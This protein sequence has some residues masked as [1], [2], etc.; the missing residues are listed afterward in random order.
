M[1]FLFLHGAAGAFSAAILFLVLGLACG[2]YTTSFIYRIPLG[3]KI[4]NDPPFCDT[5]HAPLQVRDLFPFFSWVI[6]RGKCR[7]CHV[8]VP[9]LYAVVEFTGAVLF[10]TGIFVMG[11]S[12]SLVL[13]LMLGTLL[14][15]LCAHHYQQGQFYIQIILSLLGV[16]AM[17]RTLLDHTIVG[18]VHGGYW[19]FV[20]G[21]MPWAVRCMRAKKRLPYPET[22]LLP[23]FAGIALGSKQMPSFLVVGAVAWMVFYAFAAL[24]KDEAFKRTAPV[25]A[26]SLAMI[27][28]LMFPHMCSPLWS[29]L[30]LLALGR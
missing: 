23:I 9:A 6:G 27:I 11:F 29:W 26:A 21:M 3:R 4:T 10:V 19:G 7:M 8:A 1:D 13:T 2:S 28:L 24:R 20:I 16:A 30:S 25:M 15:I 22:A 14:I 5:C 12:E 18:I 17:Q